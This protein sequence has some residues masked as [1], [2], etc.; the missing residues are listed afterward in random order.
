ML[1]CLHSS[2]FHITSWCQLWQDIIPNSFF[3]HSAI[4]CLGYIPSRLQVASEYSRPSLPIFIFS[5]IFIFIFKHYSFS[6]WDVAALF[7]SGWPWTHSSPPASVSQVLG[8]NY[9]IRLT[10]IFLKVALPAFSFYI[11]S[12]YFISRL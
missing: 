3:N 12:F 1:L 9:H 8:L 5:G 11:I 2:L 6:Y 10:L 7:S 4:L